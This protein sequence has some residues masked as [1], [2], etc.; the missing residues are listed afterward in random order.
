MS[1]RYLSAKVA[2]QVDF[3]LYSCCNTLMNELKIDEELMSAT[4]AFSL[5][6]VRC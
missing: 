1:I 6:Q 5:D 2:Q 3:F 4:G